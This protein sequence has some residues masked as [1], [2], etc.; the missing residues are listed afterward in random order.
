MG[1]A[2]RIDDAR[3]LM[4]SDR[5]GSGP[6]S[7]RA[8]CYVPTMEPGGV[9][10]P[11]HLR[12]PGDPTPIHRSPPSAGLTDLVRRFWIPVW[13]VPPGQVSEQKVLQYPCCGVVLSTDYARFFGVVR[14]LSTVSL[15]GDGWAVGVMFQA[16]AGYLV[17]GRS[18]HEVTDGSVDVATL[19]ALAGDWVHDVRRIMTDPHRPGAR[20]EAIGVV[21]SVLAPLVPVDEE[22]L[23]VNRIVDLVENTPALLRV[24]D[25]CDRLSMSQRTLQRLLT[26]RLGISPKW[27]I[28]RRRLHEA[29][30]ALQSGDVDLAALAADLGYADQAHFTRDF[31]TVTTMTP[32]E[33]ARR[34]KGS[35]L[36]RRWKDE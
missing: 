7:A 31:R 11:A 17:L 3:V 5:F 10:E 12:D 13:S 28:Q 6:V 20:A 22:G 15:S 19:P 9:D 27:L 16:A 35:E 33:L 21:E 18:V 23:Q 30:A 25:L 29:A 14:G 1:A 34:W 2:W 8:A 4:L 36:A 24:S 26:R 32:G